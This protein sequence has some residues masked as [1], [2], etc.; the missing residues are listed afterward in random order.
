MTRRGWT[1]GGVVCL[2]AL[3]M[4]GCGGA[5]RSGSER[6]T[7]MAGTA[8][9][10]ARAG[11]RTQVT[12]T[13]CFQEMKGFDNF[14][15]SDVADGT[16]AEPAA[17]RAYRI[18]QRGDFEQHVGKKVTIKGWV[19]SPREAGGTPAGK[20]GSGDLD[21]NELAEL[22]VDSIVPLSDACGK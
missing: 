11:D 10:S 15:L 4:N 17:K 6:V 7:G 18:E 2:V 20:A 8:G 19:D 9:T 13:G 12:A 3:M 16:N 14:V 21:F 1:S 22:H 5:D